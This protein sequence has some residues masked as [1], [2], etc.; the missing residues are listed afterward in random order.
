ME[1]QIKTLFWYSVL[2]K[3]KKKVFKA[4]LNRSQDCVMTDV[5]VQH[6]MVAAIL[7]GNGEE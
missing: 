7:V 1:L 2:Q 4:S 6:W 3:K 5:I